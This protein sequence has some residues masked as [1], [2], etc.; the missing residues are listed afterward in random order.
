MSFRPHRRVLSVVGAAAATAALLGAAP[1]AHA[2]S[3]AG[4]ARP[5]ANG[6]LSPQVV[7]TGKGPTGYS[8]TFRI[9]DPTAT[10]MRIKGEWSFASAAAIAAD[11]TNSTPSYGYDW[12]PG[13]FPLATPNAGSAANWPVVA[14]T[15]DERTGVWSYTTPLP[16]GVFNYSFY[17]DCTAAAPALTGCTATADPSNPVWSTAGSA[18]PSSQVY[19]P[20]DPR[21]GT[22]DDAWQGPAARGDEGA[23]THLTYGSPGH[24][25]PTDENYLSVYTPPGYNAHRRQTYPTLYL[26]HGGGGNEMD[27]STQGDLKNIL[28]NLIADHEI[29]PTVVVMPNNPT[30]DEMTDDVIPYVQQ[31]LNVG[32]DAADRAFAGL[33]GGATVVQDLLFGETPTFGYYSVWSA[34]RGLPTAEQA[35]NPQLKELLGLHIGVAVQD[36]GGLAQGNTTAEQ[37]L[38]AGDGVPFVSY[39][40]NGGHNWAY[41]RQALRDALTKVDFRATAV[42]VRTHGGSATATVTSASD[43]PAAATGTVQFQVDGKPLGRPV[44]LRGGTATAALPKHLSG[45]VGAVYSGDRLY[46][47]STSK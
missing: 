15:K 32:T 37:Q 1:A 36:L 17:R 21:F 2:A 30:D 40:V 27:W 4:P 24:T 44:A 11:P 33:S 22:E 34:P 41:W 6:S 23:L 46:N 18:E 29:Q 47:G 35:A 14:M 3:A 19:V 25:D 9:H 12:K 42:G 38:L 45:T 7:H 31:H 5:P 43:E 8:V 26:V 16:S 13:E 39:N 10:S 20:S 28:D